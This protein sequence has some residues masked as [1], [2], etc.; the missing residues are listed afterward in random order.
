VTS[1]DNLE[2]FIRGAY[3]RFNR[4]EA[5]ASGEHK[6]ASLDFY[7]PEAVY[8]NDANDPD[9]G[10][11]MGIE[12]VRQQVGQWVIAYPDLQ[13]EPLEIQTNGDHAFVWVRFS[14]HGAGSGA[15]L[16]MELAHVVTV[17]ADKVLRVEEY[18]ERVEG[19][20]AAG[21]LE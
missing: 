19:L 18:S 12:A 15:P 8:V 5:S 7:H 14:G 21:L 6:L 17:E 13:V 10:I 16:S 2:D 11:H 1:Q 3:A 20:R 9:P 4:A